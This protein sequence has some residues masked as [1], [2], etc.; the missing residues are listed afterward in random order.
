MSRVLFI[1]ASG[2]NVM[3]GPNATVA[4]TVVQVNNVYF[5]DIIPNQHQNSGIEDF[6]NYVKICPLCHTFCDVPDPS[7]PQ[8]V[9]DFFYSYTIDTDA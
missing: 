7:Y 3:R 9:C 1:L 5:L 8:Q 2:A 6:V 4:A